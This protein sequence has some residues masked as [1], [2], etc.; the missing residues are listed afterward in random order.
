MQ[1]TTLEE[2]FNAQNLTGKYQNI[3]DRGIH[4]KT[5]NDGNRDFYYSVFYVDFLFAEVVYNKINDEIIMIKSFTDIKKL[6]FYLQE[7]FS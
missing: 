5:I 2:Q 6:L 3:W 4:L 1:K 7:D